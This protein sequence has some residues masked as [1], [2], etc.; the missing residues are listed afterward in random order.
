MVQPFIDL[1]VVTFHQCSTSLTLYLYGFVWLDNPK[2]NT[3]AGFVRFEQDTGDVSK[4][5]GLFVELHQHHF[6]FVRDFL[7]SCVGPMTILGVGID[8]VTA[9]GAGDTVWASPARPTCPLPS[10]SRLRA[11]LTQR[12]AVVRG[13]PAISA[14]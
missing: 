12:A 10:S 1:G 14:M 9:T 11:T 4:L 6:S 13:T 3:V 7:G 2:S 5:S 8:T